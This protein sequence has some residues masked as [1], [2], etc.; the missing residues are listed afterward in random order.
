MFWD[1]AAAERYVGEVDPGFLQVRGRTKRAGA[2]AECSR[3]SWGW[4]RLRAFAVGMGKP[5]SWSPACLLLK[6]RSMCGRASHSQVKRDGGPHVPPPPHYPQEFKTYPQPVHQS[7]VFRL[8]LMKH[9]GGAPTAGMLSRA[10]KTS[11]N[12]DPCALSA[13]AGLY[14]DTDMECW[15]DGSD[16]LAGYDLVFQV[17]AAGAAEI[18]ACGAQHGACLQGCSSLPQEAHDKLHVGGAC[19]VACPDS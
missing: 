11:V 9:F 15:R 13:G 17:R 7:D 18:D 19:Y 1:R 10:L 3:E 5:G 6:G 14:I 12:V 16:M 4:E 2:V 8:Y